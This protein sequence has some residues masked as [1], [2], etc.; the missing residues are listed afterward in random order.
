MRYFFADNAGASIVLRLI[1][2]H[3]TKKYIM[4]TSRLQLQLSY[5]VVW[6]ARAPVWFP[7]APVWF[8]RPSYDD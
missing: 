5:A 8:P 6:F 1:I 7:I 3:T 2:L 4:S